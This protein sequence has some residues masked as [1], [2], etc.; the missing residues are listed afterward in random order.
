[1]PRITLTSGSPVIEP[2][3]YLADLIDVREKRLVT[4]FSKNGEEQDFFEWFWMV[5]GPDGD[6]Q[7][8]SLTSLS[9]HPM[10]NITKYMTALVGADKAK[11]GLDMDTDELIGKT[12]L[13]QIGLNDAGFARIEQI[14][15]AP[16]TQKGQKA[17]SPAPAPVATE[18]LTEEDDL[19]F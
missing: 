13:V 3:V 5:H 8:T 9:P 2:G 18:V 14:M 6:L 4:A 1:M 7:I 12:A 17:A 15:A 11:P 10:S 16:K 19:P